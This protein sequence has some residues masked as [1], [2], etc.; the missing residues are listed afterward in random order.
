MDRYW[1][2]GAL[3]LVMAGC[4]QADGTT[5]IGMEGSPMWMATASPATKLAVYRANCATYGFEVGTP[6]MAQCVQQEAGTYSAK[7]SA[8]AAAAAEM[9]KPVAPTYTQPVHTNCNRV[10]NYVNC[11][12]Y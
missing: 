7:A 10:G 11:T 8:Q 2:L 5:A 6:Q 1:W 12:S 3:S 9:N 4:T